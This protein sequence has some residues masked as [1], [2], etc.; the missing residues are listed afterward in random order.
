MRGGILNIRKPT[1]PTSHDIVARVR[2]ILGLRRV[3]HAGTLDP[4][5]EGVLLVCVDQATRLVEYLH[6]LPKEYTA[7]IRFGEVTDTQDS[8]GTVLQSRD[9]SGLDR[10]QVLAALEPFNGPI[11]QLPPMYS[12]VKM[13]GR[14][15]YERA[16]RGEEVERTLRFATIHSLE[17]RGFTPGPA[18]EAVLNVSCSSGTY[19]RTICHDLGQN[20][21]IGAVMTSLTR[22]A[23][24]PFSLEDASD[25]E[26][27]ERRVTA[28]EPPPWVS[29]VLALGHLA[30]RKVTPAEQEALRQ[31]RLVAV[32]CGTVGE[33]ALILS[34]RD[35]L[36]GIGQTVETQGRLAI[37]PVKVFLNQDAED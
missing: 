28:G 16:R 33:T 27:L 29:P 37:R 24:G 32:E 22:T 20:L 5:A 31:G 4:L 21:G 35:D 19:I 13:D 26:D 18:A 34:E 36:I 1:G 15:L 8:T 30:R 23:I 10:E 12:A 11:R 2:R 6:E 14:P 9:A 3:G 7:G 25:L 17:L